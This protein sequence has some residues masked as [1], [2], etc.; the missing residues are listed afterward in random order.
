MRAALLFRRAPQQNSD[1]R[2]AHGKH[3]SRRPCFAQ[4]I[5]WD[6]S[7]NVVCNALACHDDSSE[8]M[9]MANG[10]T[11][12]NEKC[13]KHLHPNRNSSINHRVF[14]AAPTKVHICEPLEW[15]P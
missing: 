1:Q 2:A 13:D 4:R 8:S 6:S 9:P 7:S 14:A 15:R 11:A 5:A 10:L 12:K 3:N